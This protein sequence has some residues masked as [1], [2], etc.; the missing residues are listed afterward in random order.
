[1]KL[2]VTVLLSVYVTHCAAHSTNFALFTPYQPVH[3]LDEGYFPRPKYF[4]HVE[5]GLLQQHPVVRFP[6]HHAPHYEGPVPELHFAHALHQQAAHQ[7]AHHTHHHPELFLPDN[8]Y[9][10]F[11]APSSSLVAYVPVQRGKPGPWAVP[12]VF[13]KGQGY[14]TNQYVAPTLMQKLLAQDPR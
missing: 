2:F 9:L 6:D 8:R 13:I 3:P 14:S 10:S 1:M 5:T 4:D 12:N 11:V 7:Q